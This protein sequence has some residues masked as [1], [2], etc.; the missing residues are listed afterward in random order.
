MVGFAFKPGEEEAGGAKPMIDEG[1]LDGIDR[2]V[3]LHVWSQ[4]P[5]GQVAVPPGVVMASADMFTLTIRGKGGHGA[6]PHLTI[7]AVVIAAEVVTALP[8][9]VS[10][11]A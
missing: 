9:R 8:T 10:L 1:A 11:D 6:Q 7:D 3:G 2:V 5:T 4:L